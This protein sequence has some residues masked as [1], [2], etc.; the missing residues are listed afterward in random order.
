MK[1]LNRGRFVFVGVIFT[2]LLGGCQNDVVE[3]QSV[4]AEV[5]SQLARAAEVVNRIEHAAY[6]PMLVEPQGFGAFR[7]PYEGYG[8]ALKNLYNRFLELEA[9]RRE[10][11]LELASTAV[12]AEYSGIDAESV[13]FDC[14]SQVLRTIPGMQS[15]VSNEVFLK[16]L[17]LAECEVFQSGQ[18]LSAHDKEFVL[19]FLS[20]LKGGYE[21][22]EL[23]SKG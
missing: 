11:I 8:N 3:E 2:V 20:L 15:S 14:V 18:L 5:N 23:Q 4:N 7:N 19:K 12:P 13:N 6:N 17:Q 22:V 9:P 1:W 21:F 10:V 16:R